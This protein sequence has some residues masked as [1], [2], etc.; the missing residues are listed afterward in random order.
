MTFISS[1][2][3]PRLKIRVK[4]ICFSALFIL[5]DVYLPRIMDYAKQCLAYKNANALW[6]N[7]PRKFCLVLRQLPGAKNFTKTRMKLDL[8]LF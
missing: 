2:L 7:E 3:V 6:H 1:S 5:N 4:T 8:G